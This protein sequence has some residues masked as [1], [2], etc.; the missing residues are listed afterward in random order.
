MNMER[1]TKLA[2]R[3]DKVGDEFD[4][5]QRDL[6]RA[7]H[8]CS[9]QIRMIGFAYDHTLTW[10]RAKAAYAAFQKAID[11]VKGD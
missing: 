1:L 11:N 4:A 9:A 10:E 5:T 7:M 8:D 2:N 3:I 6:T